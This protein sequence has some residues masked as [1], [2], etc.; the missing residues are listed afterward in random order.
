MDNCCFNRPFD[1]QG[2]VKI[3]IETE[4]VLYIQQKLIEDKIDLVWSYMLDYENNFN[5]F[6]ERRISI[7]SWKEY[8]Q[9]D[10]K[11][12]NE[13]LEYAKE[14]FESGIKAKDALHIASA[15]TANCKYFITTDEDIIKKLIN[16]KKIKIINPAELII[17]ENV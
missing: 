1:D 8:S 7:E 3:R 5:P 16:Y 17:K 9:I 13:L 14:L 15:V 10:I 2:Q 12:S 4:A 6:P 11:E